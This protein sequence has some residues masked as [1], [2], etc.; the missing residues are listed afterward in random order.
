MTR[1]DSRS[2]PPATERRAT[3][4]GLQWPG[5]PDLGAAVRAL[6][7]QVPAGRVTTFGA[8]ARGLGDVRAA[9]WTAHF[10]AE[11][12][13][14]RDVPWHRVVRANG[15]LPWRDPDARREQQLQLARE[16][17]RVV[18]DAVARS[19]I[20]GELQLS[21]P[22]LAILAAFQDR[23]AEQVSEVDE[24][25]PPR[26]YCGLDVAYPHP[27]RCVA[28]AVLLAA[29][30]LAPITTAVVE[31][32][33]AFPY[34][35]GYLACRELPALLAA[36][37][38]V[39]RQAA[40]PVLCLVDGQGRLH[41]RRAGVACC[42][43]VL[44]DMPTIGVGKSLL[45]GKVCA[46]EPRSKSRRVTAG[47]ELIGV[48][49]RERPPLYI[50]VGHRI[51]LAAATDVVQRCLASDSRSLPAP[52]HWADRLSHGRPIRTGPSG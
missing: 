8:I 43:G 23:V 31:Q 18:D 10:L 29:D 19:D 6:L 42:F 36:W 34:L 48:Q 16:G 40:G 11:R 12:T 38:A 14:E 46:P 9:R 44:A 5:L 47:D 51:S 50:S 26:C 15:E 45:C 41:P 1:G 22:P 24:P 13:S 20:E 21:Q 32:A 3:T 28:A 30:T 4:R 2:P 33:V 52:T 35:P 25:L 49:V 39:S 17:I 27:K 37:Q 7:A